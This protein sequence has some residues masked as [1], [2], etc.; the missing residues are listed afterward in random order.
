LVSRS[1]NDHLEVGFLYAHMHPQVLLFIRFL[2]GDNSH[3]TVHN[4]HHNVV[5]PIIS[6]PQNHNLIIITPLGDAFNP[7][8]FW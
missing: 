8:H 4:S 3:V 2:D 6:Y 1:T 7:S 5:K